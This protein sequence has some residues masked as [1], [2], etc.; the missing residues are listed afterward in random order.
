[1]N[2]GGVGMIAKALFEAI[3]QQARKLPYI[4]LTVPG[5]R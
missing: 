1:M 4:G 3:T 2:A 5:M